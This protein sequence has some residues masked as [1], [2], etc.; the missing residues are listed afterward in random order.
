M[1]AS[2]LNDYLTRSVSGVDL[3]DALLVFPTRCFEH[4]EMPQVAVSVLIPLAMTADLTNCSFTANVCVFLW[5]GEEEQKLYHDP[6]GKVADSR[7][8][9]TVLEREVIARHDAAEVRTSVCVCFQREI[10]W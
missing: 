3:G 5:V 9:R 7:R 10:K 1:A 2:S 8:E 4:A 6:T